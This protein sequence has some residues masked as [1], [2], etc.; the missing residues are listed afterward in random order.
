MQVIKYS[1]LLEY[2][3]SLGTFSKAAQSELLH[4]WGQLS[5]MS[6]EDAREVL[7]ASME[8][9]VT[10]YGDPAALMAAEFM[11][12]SLPTTM[13]RTFQPILS[14]G[15]TPEQIESE[16]RYAM[17][18]WAKGLPEQTIATLL[19]ALARYVQYPAR[20]TVIDNARRHK[21]LRFARVPTGAKTCE[22]CLLLASRGFVYWS[23]ENA[24]E[25]SRFHSHCDC[26]VIAGYADETEIAGYDPDD[27]YRRYREAQ[28]QA[29]T[30]DLKGILKGYRHDQKEAN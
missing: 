2:Q 14:S 24:G 27:L 28:E 15:V 20:Q 26:L 10:K 9:L 21:K 17:G 13:T 3:R 22:F 16:V 30:N 12:R 6:I 19:A 18:S 4:I 1:E 11:E 25:F 8:G 7:I 29:K 5:R 23:R